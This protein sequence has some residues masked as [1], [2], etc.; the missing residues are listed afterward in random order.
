LTVSEDNFHIP[1]RVVKDLII[2]SFNKSETL[3]DDALVLMK[4][5]GNSKTILGLLI[6]SLEEIGKALLLKERLNGQFCDVEKCIDN[7]IVR[8]ETVI[9]IARN[10]SNKKEWN[11]K[12]EADFALGWAI[13]SVIT[14]FTHYY[15]AFHKVPLNKEGLD[16]STEIITKRIREIKE[17]IFN[18]G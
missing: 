4:N 8:M 5:E 17:A 18:C 14:N 16:Q 1:K 11:I 6:Y 12:N 9:G 3:I 10:E 13:G 7:E 15:I 2:D